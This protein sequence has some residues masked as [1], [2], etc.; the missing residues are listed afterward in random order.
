[1]GIE[2]THAEIALSLDVSEKEVEEMDKRLSRGDAS[3]DLPVNEGE[4]RQIARVEL[5]EGDTQNPEDVVEGAEMAELVKEYLDEFKETLKDKDLLI[6]EE[7]M[8]A[9]EPRTL[10]DLG[11]QFGISRERVRQLEARVTKNLRTYLQERL[12]DAVEMNS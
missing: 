4:G 1:M 10:Q 11:D 8:V 6:F 7:R 9:E 12:G 2:P 5:M 3:L